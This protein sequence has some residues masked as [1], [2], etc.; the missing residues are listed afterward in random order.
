MTIK[1]FQTTGNKEQA[2]GFAVRYLLPYLLYAFA[3]KYLT[4]KLRTSKKF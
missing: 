2:A 3:K 4:T 1:W